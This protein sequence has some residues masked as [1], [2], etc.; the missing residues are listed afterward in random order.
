MTAKL[1]ELDD[2]FDL[3]FEKSKFDTNLC[4]DL[5]SLKTIF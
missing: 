1:P 4:L 2:D 3:T 5:K